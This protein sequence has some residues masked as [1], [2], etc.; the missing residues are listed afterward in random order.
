[1]RSWLAA[2]WSQWRSSGHAAGAQILPSIQPP[3]QHKPPW[4]LVSSP[5]RFW[6]LV[7]SSTA[8]DLH[9]SSSHAVLCNFFHRGVSA[10]GR[11]EPTGVTFTHTGVS[12]RHGLWV[13]PP[14]WMHFQSKFQQM[15]STCL[16]MMG[17]TIVIHSSIY[18][19]LKTFVQMGVNNMLEVLQLHTHH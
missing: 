14:P 11:W 8:V 10:G 3:L 15:T 13:D 12:F 6:L 16:C 4:L 2:L 7:P 19:E 17:K 18:A 5:N 1:M 9:C